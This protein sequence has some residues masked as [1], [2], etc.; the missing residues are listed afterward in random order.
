MSIES[1]CG[2]TPDEILA[3]IAPEEATM[4]HAVSVANSIYKKRLASLREFPGIPKS[5]RERLGTV[6]GSGLFPPIRTVL[7]DDGS[8]KFL[9]RN[10][11]GQLYE[12]VFIP[13]GKRQT[14]CIS[15]QSGCRMGCPFCATGKYGFFG[16]LTAR[17]MIN[18]VISLPMAGQITHVVFMGMG[19][20]MDNLGNVLKACRILTAEWGLTIA[21]KNVTVSTVGV[22]ASARE[23]LETSPYNFSLSLFSPFPEE[24]IR[25][26]AAERKNPAHRIIDL[27]K[28]HSGERKRRMTIAYVM[29]KGINDSD[30]HLEALK[31]LAG[32]SG[33]RV[34][35]LP[36]H[37]L[38]GD[39]NESSPPDL[40]QHFK[41]NLM[42]SGIS[43][44]VRRSRGADI[45]AACGLLA[46]GLA[47]I[48]TPGQAKQV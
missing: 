23:F 33:I 43:A 13:E 15:T 4:R 16:N 35:L 24:R 39:L 26:V 22:E 48:S 9:F 1:L 45:S 19:E 42:I 18:Q 46:S 6:A 36:Y 7:S 41:H 8:V 3:L 29:V 34:N 20:P 21:V 44:S 12:T 37:P 2:L 27:M 38:P 47:E 5:L 30:R 10:E 40:M 32:N 28:Q 17:D 14:V 31:H 11:P 25:F